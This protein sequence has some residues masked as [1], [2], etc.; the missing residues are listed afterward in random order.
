MVSDTNK[1]W[2]L[3]VGILAVIATLTISCTVFSVILF[4]VGA[5]ASSIGPAM[6]ITLLKRHTHYI[7]LSATM[8]AGMMT[9]LTTYQ[10][11][12]KAQHLY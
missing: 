5:V 9:A 10:F 2:T 12:K 8:L 1:P 6:L 7:A 4:E 3:L 11:A